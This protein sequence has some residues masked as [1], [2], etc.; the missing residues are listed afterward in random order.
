MTPARYCGIYDFEL[1]PYALGDVLTWNIQTAI[2][3]EQLGRERVDVYVCMDERYPSSIY[4]RGL[5]TAEN[6]GLFFNELYGAFGTH[7]RLGNLFVFRDRDEMLERLR[8]ASRADAANAEALADYEQ[9][10]AHRDDEA[11]LNAYFTKY[12]YFHEQINAFAAEH[13]RIPLLAPSLGCGP[14]IAALMA[15]RF[16]GSRVVAFHLRLRRLDAGYGGEHTYTR[17]SDFLEWYEFLKDAARVHPDVQFVVMGRLQ[18]KPVELLRLPN[19]TSLRTLG[20]GLGHELTLMLASD[21]FIG[22]SSGFAA[23]ANFSQL[24]YFITRMNKESCN[25]YRIPP[26]TER[27][28]FATPQQWLVYEPETRD[29]LMRLLQRG[30]AGA[31]AREGQ[32]VTPSQAAVDVPQWL[33]QRLQ[34]LHPGATTTRFFVDDAYADGETAYLI[35]PRLEQARTAAEQ[36]S[37]A[38]AQNIVSRVQTLFPRMSARF[39]DFLRLKALVAGDAA[40]AA[41]LSLRADALQSVNRHAPPAVSV[42]D[43]LLPPGRRARLRRILAIACREP[44]TLPRRVLN[45]LRRMMEARRP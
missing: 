16:A 7:P 45:R 18:E 24:P 13:G 10:L 27:L 36:G 34:C 3:C 9:A 39:P 30:L 37:R 6:C 17:D 15:K 25:A 4:Q 33:E 31:S 44:H 40:A 11:A 14:D 29:L 28:P 43:T 19:V 41:A 32:P 38:E 12:I 20:L 2:R 26:G 22:T 8:E 1:L 35:A 23:M 42:L 5:V 21:L